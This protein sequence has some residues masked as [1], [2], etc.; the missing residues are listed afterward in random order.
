MKAFFET[1]AVAFSM[2]SALPM[3]HV[4]WKERNLRYVMCAFPLVGVLLGGLEYGWFLLARSIDAGVLLY[5][6]VAAALPVLVTGG[7]HLDGFCD[8]VDA[9]SSHGEREKKL[10]IL[11]DPHI[12]AFG[13]MGCALWLLVCFGLY[14]E[15]YRHTAGLVELCFLFLLSRILS[16]L[17]VVA[18]RC[19]K[20]S[21][22][23][24][25]FQSGAARRNAGAILSAMLIL[26][27]AGMLWCS[28]LYGAICLLAA[29]AIFLCYRRMSYRQFGGITGDLAGWFLQMCELMELAALVLLNLIV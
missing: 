6:A 17:S 22:L 20:D 23:V 14:G 11:K 25:A 18:F 9:L 16:G 2:Y 5:A 15:L 4:E 24:H 27:A 8:T 3:P 13:V 28:P 29:L 7:I 19:A 26:T 10:S 21:G 12:G 1:I